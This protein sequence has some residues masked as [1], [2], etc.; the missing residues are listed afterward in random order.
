[1]PEQN[2]SPEIEKDKLWGW[3]YAA[4]KWQNDL[5]KSMA[6]K[7]LDI[8]EPMGD[9]NAPKTMISH[10][11]I[12]P[13]AMVMLGALGLGG[14]YLYNQDKEPPPQPAAVNTQSTDEQ[15][16]REVIE[17]NLKLRLFHNGQEV[18]AVPK[19]DY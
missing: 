11:G 3:W 10:N 6:Y 14:W 7:G 16:R 4:K 19:K 12:S 5:H 9:I 18:Q 2:S 17:R 13:A 15:I 8:P 1:M